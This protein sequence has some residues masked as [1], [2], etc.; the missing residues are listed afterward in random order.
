ML[1]FL[2]CV[3]K[4]GLMDDAKQLIMSSFMKKTTNPVSVKA[5]P[6]NDKSTVVWCVTEVVKAVT[7]LSLHEV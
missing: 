7:T 6:A 2:V 5:L 4:E 1:Q 3:G